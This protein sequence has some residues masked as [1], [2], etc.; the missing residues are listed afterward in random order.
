MTQKQWDERWLLYYDAYWRLS[1]NHSKAFDE[2]HAAMLKFNGPR[3]DGEPGL[4]WWVKIAALSFGVKM[5]NTVARV[6]TALLYAVGVAV[7]AYQA[8]VPPI[9]VEGWVGLA[10]AFVVAFWGKFSSAS[11]VVAANRTGETFSTTPRN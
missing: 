5:N 8:T 6:I 4:P 3:P 9:S 2:A 1:R 11:S 10:V 7:A